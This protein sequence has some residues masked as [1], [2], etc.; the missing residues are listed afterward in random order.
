MD[1]DDLYRGAAEVLALS[2]GEYRACLEAGQLLGSA[3][4]GTSI[5]YMTRQIQGTPFRLVGRM[6][7]DDLR[8]QFFEE[9]EERVKGDPCLPKWSGELYPEYHRGTYTA[10]ARNKRFNRK[11]EL[12]LR[13]AELL[14]TWARQ[15]RGA[16]YPAQ[17]LH[18]LWETVLTLQ[19][20]DILPGSSIRKVYDDA[21]EMYTDAAAKVEALRAGAMAA[22]AGGMAGDVVVFNTLSSPRDDVVWFDAPE[23]VA[24]LRDA[25]GNEYPAQYVEGRACAF[26]SDLPPMGAKPLWFVMGPARGVAPD[27]DAQG[28]D[29]PFFTGCFDGAMRIASLVDKRNG[30]QLCKPGQV[31]NRIVCYEN[32]PHNFDAW[33][34][35]IYY[36][37]RHW[38]VD[39]VTGVEVVSR[40]PVLTRLRVR[41]AYNRSTVVQDIT[42][43]ADLPRVDFDTTVDWQEDHYMLK[44]HFPVDIFYNDAAF[45]I[46]YG[47]VRRATH[48]NTSWDVARFEVCAHKWA[49]VSEPGYGF[50]LMNDCKYGY[51]VDEDSVAL[52]LLKSSTDPNPVAD[53]EVHRF[54]Y[55]IAPHVGDWRSANVPGLAYGL[56]IPVLSAGG[57]GKGEAEQSFAAVDRDNVIVEAVKQ[58]LDGQDTVIRLYES[59]GARTDVTLTLGQQ[60]ASVRLANLLE[61]DI[62]PVDWCGDKVHLTL[63]PYEIVTLRVRE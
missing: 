32:R 25:R 45:D 27:V 7:L 1:K 26:V 53:R 59:H 15:L 14:C 44:A 46:Q 55:A 18:D 41:Y 47:N 49:D 6:L 39:E 9:L 63:K 29:T 28:F 33:D 5:L 13:D 16:E 40:G 54:T 17:Q 31:L 12:A 61:D 30:R 60:P 57:W 22:I 20:H 35:N 62:G 52:T 34:I 36:R 51:S 3:P 10:M 2:E 42:F 43:Y 11:M 50:A 23:G 56:N 58:A 38:E 4:D 21:L 37:L 8:A 24:A 48:K 19:F